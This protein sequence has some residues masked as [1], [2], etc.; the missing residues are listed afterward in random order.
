MTSRERPT[1]RASFLQG[2]CELVREL[3]ADPDSLAPTP[4]FDMSRLGDPSRLLDYLTYSNLLDAAAHATGCPHF[5]LLLGERHGLSIVGPL[6]LLAKHCATVGAAMSTLSRY[7]SIHSQGAVYRLHRDGAVAFFVRE[8]NLPALAHKTQ[9]QDISLCEIAQ[10]IRELCGPAWRPAAVYFTH[11]EPAHPQVYRKVFGCPVYFAQEVQA[12]T[13]PASDLD[14]PLALA[15]YE[16]RQFLETQFSVQGMG[17]T[18]RLSDKVRDAIKDQMAAGTCT[19]EAVAEQLSLHSR[20]VHRRLKAESTTFSRLLEETRRE[21]ATGL[22]TQTRL[23][24]GQI[25]L[26]LGYSESAAFSR[27][28]TRWFG[29]SPSRWRSRARDSDGA[30]VE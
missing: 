1:T 15:D 19:V 4:G 27:A 16:T 14:R 18:R 5:G 28:F 12:I 25:S 29:T 26:T 22:L 7:H 9:L 11:V 10:L 30:A 2:Y 3:G 23:S 13:M 20:T 8:S 6:G 24:V 17:K 21:L